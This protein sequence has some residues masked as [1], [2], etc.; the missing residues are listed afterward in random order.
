MATEHAKKLRL[1]LSKLKATVSIAEDADG[2]PEYKILV[3]DT[4][5]LQR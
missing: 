5:T 3:E 2:H 1:D 4:K